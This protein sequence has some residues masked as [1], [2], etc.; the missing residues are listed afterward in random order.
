MTTKATMDD[1]LAQKTFAIVGVSRD[2]KKFGNIVYRDLKKK[3]FDVIPVN[4]KTDS[5]DGDPCYPNLAALPKPA[6]G[7]VIIVPPDRTESVVKEAKEAG[8]SRVWMQQGAGSKAAIQFC[9][10]NGMNVVHGHCIMMFTDPTGFH[11]FHRWVW[12]ILGKLPK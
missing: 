1:F 9:E 12:K 2:Q 4:P 11:K 6:G 8:I 5:I 7:V 10:E 3:G